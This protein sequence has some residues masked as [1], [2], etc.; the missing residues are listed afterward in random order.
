MR[1]WNRLFY[2]NILGYHIIEVTDPTQK[3]TAMQSHTQ[4]SVIV[5]STVGPTR[6]ARGGMGRRKRRNHAAPYT[7]RPAAAPTF[8]PATQQVSNAVAQYVY[9][10]N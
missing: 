5:V 3:V 2:T 10:G 7:L 1:T 8:M 9:G 4:V 6:P